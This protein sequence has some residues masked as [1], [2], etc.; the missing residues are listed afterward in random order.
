MWSGAIGNIPSGFALFDG[1]NGTP[2]LTDRFVVSVPNAGTNP[3]ATGGSHSTTLTV[4][5]LPSHSHT[6]SGNTS[7]AGS[8]SHSGTTANAGAHTH[9]MPGYPCLGQVV[10]YHGIIGR[11][12]KLPS[13]PTQPLPQVITTIRSVRIPQVITRTQ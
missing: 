9:T 3:G 6:A 11:I 8:H 4:A 1:T 13:I 5:Q 12:L 7:S 10:Q 2:D